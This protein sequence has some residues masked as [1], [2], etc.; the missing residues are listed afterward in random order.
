MY[1]SQYV[2]VYIYIFLLWNKTQD[3]ELDFYGINN[4]LFKHQWL[5]MHA[6]SWK[7]FGSD[8]VIEMDLL[9]HEQ[10]QKE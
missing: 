7:V 1:M 8:E 5:Y 9:L 3:I 4:T 6:F 10:T 2:F